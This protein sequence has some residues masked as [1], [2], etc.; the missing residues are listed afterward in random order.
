MSSIYPY[1]LPLTSTSTTNFQL[2]SQ[3]FHKGPPTS[4]RSFSIEVSTNFHQ[5]SMDK[6]TSMGLEFH[7]SK[8]TS[9]EVGESRFTSIEFPME[10]GG[11]RFTSMDV[12]R[13]VHGSA[14]K[15]HCRWKLKLPLLS[16]SAASTN[17]FSG[18][19]HELPYNTT[20][21]HPIPRVSQTS[22]WFHKTNPNPN[23]SCL[24]WNY[25]HEN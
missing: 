4:G 18:S 24:S 6:L 17:I 21:F 13:S 10:V 23:F 5:S 9:M 8:L 16:S 15:F 7:G 19:L 1:V 22:G 11:S 20:Y 14:W 3:D 12:G 25:L 2:L